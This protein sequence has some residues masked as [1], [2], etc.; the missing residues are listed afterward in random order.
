M[1]SAKTQSEMHPE[2]FPWDFE[3]PNTPFWSD[4][5]LAPPLP[6][7]FL[8]CFTADE[9]EEMNLDAS[10]HLSKQDNFLLL[11]HHIQTKYKVREAEDPHLQAPLPLYDTAW[12]DW[13]RLMTGIIHLQDLSGLK[14]E[15]EKSLE[16]L[17]QHGRDGKRNLSGVNMMASFKMEQGEYSD[18][19]TM[20][21][22]VL[23]RLQGHEMLGRDSPQALG[24]I[25]R[26]IECL[27]KGGKLDESGRLLDEYRTL[28]EDMGDGKF[29]KY[30]EEEQKEV[31]KLVQGLKD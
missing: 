8:I 17:I 22:E 13:Q 3:N 11:L 16:L 4:P 12:E 7:N 20:L 2:K 18:A 26:L 5:A 24:C 10:A 15:Q 19:E 31:E 6:R 29:G 25:R 14:E 27:W 28:V 30:Q 23:P 21:Q 9:I 1:T